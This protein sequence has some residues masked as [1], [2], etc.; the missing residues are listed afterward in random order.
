MFLLA[1]LIVG[2]SFSSCGR[3]NDED[4]TTTPVPGPKMKSY[5]DV[6]IGNQHS[7]NG[8]YINMYTGKV[9]SKQEAYQNQGEID[10]GF[11]FNNIHQNFLASPYELL[12]WCLIIRCNS[13][14]SP[15]ICIGCP[16]F[17]ILPF[18]TIS[19]FKTLR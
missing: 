15:S 16:S 18:H 14:N 8:T 7:Q 5:N 1:L 17:V 13:F 10:F 6:K 9:Y 2:V 3:S 12:A 11:F 4:P 19:T